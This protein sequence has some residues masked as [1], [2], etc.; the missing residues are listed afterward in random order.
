MLHLPPVLERERRTALLEAQIE[1]YRKTFDHWNKIL[2]D[3]DPHIQLVR[4]QDDANA[5]GLKPGFWHVL[6]NAPGSPPSIIV[7]QGPNGE[8]RE[9]DSGLLEE[10]R[11]D[12]MWSSRSLKERKEKQ[13]AA[14][15]AQEREEKREK[16]ERIDE[17][18]E[19]Y[20]QANTTSIFVK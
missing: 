19:R 6:R 7:H 16:D 20:H 8:Y 17:I 10:L 3:I 2:Q 12:D 9:P 11:R 5:P 18:I 1:S 13:K 14:R 15:R 4:A